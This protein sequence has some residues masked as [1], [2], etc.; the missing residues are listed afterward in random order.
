M[1]EQVRELIDAI[2]GG[3]TLEIE[4]AFNEVMS[5]KL[6][7]AIDVHR[8]EISSTLFDPAEVGEE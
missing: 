8:A 4:S 1:N 7:D 5:S 3:K 6:V 2:A